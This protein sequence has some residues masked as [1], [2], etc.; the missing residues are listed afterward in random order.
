AGGHCLPAT[1]LRLGAERDELTVVDDQLGCP[2]FTPHL[3]RALVALCEQRPV[4]IVHVTGSGSCSWYELAKEIV[5]RA[6]LDCAIKPGSTAEQ[7][8]PAPRPPYS[9][10]ASERDDEAPVLPHWLQ[11]LEEYLAAKVRGRPR[12]ARGCGY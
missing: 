5:A 4:G 7:G 3:A 2:T 1:I 11:G 9:V 8:R 10:L 6:D 12:R